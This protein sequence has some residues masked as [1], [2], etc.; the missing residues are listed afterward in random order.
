MILLLLLLLSLSLLVLPLTRT[1]SGLSGVNCTS[2]H[3]GPFGSKPIA[4]MVDCPGYCKLKG[5]GEG[6]L[7]PGVLQNQMP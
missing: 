2:Q 6:Y 1:F 7:F 5:S 4:K 3:S